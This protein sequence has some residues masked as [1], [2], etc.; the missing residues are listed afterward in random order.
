MF[1]L[2][3]LACLFFGFWRTLKFAVFYVLASVAVGAALMLFF[4]GAS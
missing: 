4:I 1:W 3:L 2:F